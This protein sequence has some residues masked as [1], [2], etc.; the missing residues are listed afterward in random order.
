MPNAYG[1]QANFHAFADIPDVS[2]VAAHEHS[3]R[4]SPGRR[5]SQRCR[6]DSAAFDRVI[7]QFVKGF[8][9]CDAH[10]YRNS[11]VHQHPAANVPPELGQIAES[12]VP[13][14]ED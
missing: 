4:A 5:R 6:F 12:M 14:S 8:G 10:S 7:G 2:H 11:G 1:L 13:D 3:Y 9:V